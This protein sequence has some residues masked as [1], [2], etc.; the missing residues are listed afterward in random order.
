MSRS[1]SMIGTLESIPI[2]PPARPIVPSSAFFSD[3]V[4]ASKIGKSTQ[5]P[6]TSMETIVLSRPVL[7]DPVLSDPVLSDPVGDSGPVVAQDHQRHRPPHHSDSQGHHPVPEFEGLT[8][9]RASQD[10]DVVQKGVELDQSGA[11]AD[12]AGCA[13]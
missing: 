5:A 6:F 3:L 7:S 4:F 11:L 9:H 8:D 2:L 1:A 12:Q 10:L 13:P